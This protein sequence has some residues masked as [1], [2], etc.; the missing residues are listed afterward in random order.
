M[1]N[2]AV[3]I[4]DLHLDDSQHEITELFLDFLKTEA[5]KSNSLYILGDL[6][7][8]WIG[9][10][11]TSAYNKKIINALKK[12]SEQGKQLFFMAGNRDFLIG[13]KFTQMTGA[14]ILPDPS[15]IDINGKTIL[16]THGDSLCTDD[17]THL[18][19]RRVIQHPI[20]KKIIQWLPLRLRRHI[21]KKLR[22]KSRQHFERNNMI[23]VDV[24]NNAVLKAF[25]EH[26]VELMIHGHTHKPGLH[27]HKNTKRIVLGA[28]HSNLKLERDIFTI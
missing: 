15:L 28:W 10:D 16:L 27:Q 17:L 21:A 14:T 8:A 2:A 26:K 6:F 1:S 3:F 25:I 5:I 19:Y 9:D 22:Q 24:N 13:K 18:K 20:M 12:Y 11:D 23:S 7:E 4:A